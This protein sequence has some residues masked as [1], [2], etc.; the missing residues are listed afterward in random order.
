MPFSCY[1]HVMKTDIQLPEP[2]PEP[3]KPICRMAARLLGWSFSYGTYLLAAL[4]WYLYDWFHAAAAL[5]LGFV[6][7]GIVR[8]KVR[9]TSIPS[10]QQEYPY[11]DQAIAKWFIVRRT[12]C[13]M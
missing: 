2:T 1:N 5:L 12:L 8:A 13:D 10:A 4:A 9:N 6:V 3:V 11:T 7:F